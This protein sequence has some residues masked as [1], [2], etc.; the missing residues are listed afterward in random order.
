MKVTIR[1]YTSNLTQDSLDSMDT[2]P[3]DE[4]D[5]E[6][7]RYID[8]AIAAVLAEYPEADVDVEPGNGMKSFVAWVD[9]GDAE[10]ELR[11]GDRVTAV[12]QGMLEQTYELWCQM[13]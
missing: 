12:V 5:A 9:A 8:M 2:I 13:I 7:R 1:I 4:W 10:T 6:R 11:E 3:A